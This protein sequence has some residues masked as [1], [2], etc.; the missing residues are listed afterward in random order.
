MVIYKHSFLPTEHRSF[1]WKYLTLS[2]ASL[3][4]VWRIARYVQSAGGDAY[5]F[6]FDKYMSLGG[7]KMKIRL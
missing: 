1:A 2:V 4:T 7:R 3:A 5:W 6:P